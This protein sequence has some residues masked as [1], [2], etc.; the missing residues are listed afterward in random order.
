MIG[1]IDILLQAHN[2]NFP[3]EPVFTFVNSAQSFRIRNVP[4][5]I[6]QWSITAVT[7][8]VSYPDGTT[9]AKE[10]VLTGG[11]WV[12]T[13][14]GCATS[15]TCENGFVVTASGVDE[16]GHTVSNYVLGAGDL[17][18]KELDGTIAPG[19]TAA[20]MYFYDAAPSQP[21]KGD[22]AFIEGTLNVWDGTDWKPAVS[23]TSRDTYIYFPARQK[24]YK[25][26]AEADEDGNVTVAVDQEGVTI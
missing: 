12:A 10:C 16:N 23:G 17:Y 7:V 18:V 1:T 21:K 2:P 11:V 8:N 13:V 6:G 25:L 20:R 3:L 14:D 15:G 26:V 9:L 4:K 19:T 22:A 24:Y 5:R